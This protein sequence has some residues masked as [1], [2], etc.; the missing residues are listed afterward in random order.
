MMNRSNKTA[1]SV[2][3]SGSSSGGLTNGQKNDLRQVFEEVYSEHRWR[4]VLGN[5]IRGVAFGLGTF[6]GGTIVVALVVWM[7]SKTVDIFPPV[8]DFI[9]KLITE[10]NRNR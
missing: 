8:R 7:L 3:E 6:I 1:R 2:H 9:E 5:F 4:I 10:I